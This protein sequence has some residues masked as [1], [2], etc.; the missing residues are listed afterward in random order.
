MI[1]QGSRYENVPVLNVVDDKGNSHPTVMI[2]TPPTVRGDFD[3][4]TVQYR[5]RLDSIAY[6]TWGNPN[7]WWVIAD[8]NPDYAF[9]PSEIPVGTHIRIP[10]LNL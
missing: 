2:G 9:Y 5:D 3:Y 4:Y 1:F 7:L 8:M 10:V 6:K